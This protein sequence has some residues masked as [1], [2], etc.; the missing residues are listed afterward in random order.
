MKWETLKKYAIKEYYPALLLELILPP[1]TLD[2]LF[3]YLSIPTFLFAAAAIILVNQKI[4][5][6]F[7]IFLSVW[8]I[9]AA[10]R[11]LYYSYYFRNI[12]DRANDDVPLIG[13][14][15]ARLLYNSSSQDLLAGFFRTSEGLQVMRRAGIFA[16]DLKKYVVNRAIFISSD[17]VSFPEGQQIT[18]TDYAGMLFDKDQEFSQFLFSNSI[19]RADFL[20]ICDWVVEREVSAKLRKRWWSRERLGRIPGIGKAWTY[21]RLYELEKYERA[22]TPVPTFA[23]EVHEVYGQKEL[24]SLE[25]ILVRDHEANAFLVGDD[26]EAKLEIISRLDNLIEEG[27]IMP[28]L[29]HKRVF[30]FDTDLLT[31]TAKSKSELEQTLLVAM[32]EAA[33]AGNVILVFPDFPTFVSSAESLGTN[34]VSFLDQFFTTP[35]LQIIA[36]SDVEHFHSVIERNPALMERFDK[37]ILENI[38]ELNTIKVLENQVILLENRTGL[39]FTFGAL[40]EVVTSAERYFSSNAVTPERAINLLF[41]LAPHM[42]STGRNVVRKED[43]QELVRA[44]TGI[45]TGVVTG[46]ERDKLLDLENILHHR[47]IGQDEAVS[48][49]A[50]AVRR[51][52][53]GIN[54]PNRPLASFLFLGPTGVGKTETTKALADV[55]FESEARIER[56]DMS[57]YSGRDALPKLIGSYGSNQSGVLSSLIREHPYG[58]LLL[59]EFEKTIPEVMNLFLQILDEGFFSD[60][61]GKKVNARN[62]LII[63]TSNAGADLIWDAVKRGED[64][65]HARELILESIV[66]NNII[67]PEL[68][69]RFDGV[70]IFH[71]LAAE[72]LEKIARLQLDGL[73]K[74]LAARGMNLGITDELV[75]YVMKFGVDPKFGARPMARAIQDKVEQ[76]IAEKI[77]RGSIKPGAEISLSAADL[78]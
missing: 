69:N 31:A 26:I 52:R 3:T 66:H 56:L 18:F 61:T 33:E 78:A 55:F 6:L 15:L 23:Y 72:H 9:V 37:V 53:S 73:K 46:A 42:S 8:L 54:N 43:V 20:A 71:P 1:R 24:R 67:K 38:S 39:F 47:I 36:L 29:E 21:G 50:N 74:R 30:L 16:E 2:A 41:E 34:A 49:I 44:K 13:F 59:D 10:L 63:A 77:I 48:A 11:A 76:V 12:P 70:I 4:Y 25:D 51:A 7:F 45:P 35:E 17:I 57:E 40:L 28:E 68:L 27:R 65:S 22:L 75:Q 60:M 64:L 62:L 58:V 5:G 14:E 32:R 19:Q